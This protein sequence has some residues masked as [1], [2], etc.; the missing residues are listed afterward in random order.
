MSKS[1]GNTV[2]PQ[3]MIKQYGADI[4][5]LWVASADYADDLRIGKE[6]INTTVD[7]YRKL[8]NTIRWM[9]G[10]LAHWKRSEDVAFEDMPELERLMLH[11]LERAR[12]GRP[13]GLRRPTTTSAW[14]RPSATS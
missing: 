9:L 8:R 1:L 5:R 6:I 14:S 3:D 13:R 4:L 12:C 10:N 11:R 7:S 2:A